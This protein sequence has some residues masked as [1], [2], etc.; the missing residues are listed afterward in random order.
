MT[1]EPK[2]QRKFCTTREAAEILGVSLKTAQ[3]WSESGLLEAW[4]TDGGHRRI[5]RSSVERLLVDGGSR[6]VNDASLQ[7]PN[8]GF[9]ILVA[10]DETILRKLYSIRLSSWPMSPQVTIVPN[11]F[12]A[13]LKIGQR[14]PDLLITDLMMP[15]MDG[16]R[17]LQTLRE[18]PGLESMAI[19]VV[20]GLD[21]AD[22][23]AQGG[24]PSDIQVF[25]KP[26]P[27]DAIENI[28]RALAAAKQSSKRANST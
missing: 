6:R 21:Q 1:K 16:F 27:F 28:A 2:V 22:I 9:H 23:E 3:L 10:E 14:L 15:E 17:M 20:T 5:F 12:Q 26:I 13:L 19:V 11:G 7:T 4:R 8:D 24:L 25:P 18:S